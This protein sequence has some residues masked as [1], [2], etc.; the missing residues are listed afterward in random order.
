MSNS[1]RETDSLAH[2]FAVRGNFAISCFEQVYLFERTHGRRVG[3][4]LVVTMNQ[5]KRFY[6]F[7][8]GQSAREGIELGAITDFGKKLF[9]LICGRA[10]YRDAHACRSQQAGHEI[11][12]GGLAGAIRAHET[13]NAGTQTDVDTIHPEYLAIKLG[14]VVKYY[15]FADSLIVLQLAMPI[16][17]KLLPTYSIHVTTCSITKLQ[18]AMQSPMFLAHDLVRFDFR[19]ER[20]P[21]KCTDEE[22]AAQEAQSGGFR[23]RLRG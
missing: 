19:R 12:Q 21:N 8:A 22:N 6:E 9:R 16:A 17:I 13:S 2:S 3:L 10:Q 5:Q 18:L 1:L 20:M 14:D 4:F 23:S 7:A 15:R 11:H